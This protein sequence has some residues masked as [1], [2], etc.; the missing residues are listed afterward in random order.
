MAS[1]DADVIVIGS[2]PAG[3]TASA[4]LAE[5]GHQVLMI[6][7]DTHPRFHIGESL[8]PM[9][10]PVLDR[11]GIKLD[12]S[13]YLLKN[14][15]EFIDEVTGQRRRFPLAGQHQPHQV[16]RAKFDQM[17]AENAVARG[18]QL[19]Q[20]DAVRAV[21]I[22]ADGV[23][24][25]TDSA[26][27]RARYLIDAS[28]RSAFM[29]RMRQGISRIDNLGRFSLYTHYRNA[30][31]AAAQSAY[32]SGDVMILMLDIGWFWIIPLVGNRLSVGL[33][34]KRTDDLPARGAALFDRYRAASPIL[35]DLLAGAEQESPVRSE[36]DFSFSNRQ[37]FGARYACC[38]DAAG[39][40][41]P[42][43][44]SGVFMAVTIAERIADRV[45]AA[46]QSDSEGDPRLH[47]Q[48]DTV[49]DHGF[50]SM[51]LFVE[52]FY[53]YDL[54]HHLFFEAARDDG[55]RN[56]IAGLLAGDLWSE[57]NN[58][59]RMLLSGRQNRASNG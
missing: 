39:F 26:R 36:A 47:E 32:A 37:R 11:L 43:F 9:G 19:R 2:G 52:R 10:T 23:D 33:V 25:D 1:H 13:E 12:A 4:L 17:L 30:T 59:Q 35:N 31:S 41:D 46:L 14:G 55:I 57:G 48:D 18:A 53:Q 21:S 22:D 7:R 3:S 58:F 8:L 15:A 54:V 45:H 28:G 29:G 56:E 27:F 44:S 34:V 6:D 20:G 40:L 42:V 5:Y 38:G 50:R 49:Y 16:E 51:L 24:V